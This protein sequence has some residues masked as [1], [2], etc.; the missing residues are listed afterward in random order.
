MCVI[1]V[2]GAETGGQTGEQQAMRASQEVDGI[3]DD[4]SLGWVLASVCVSVCTQNT[5]G[6]WGEVGAW[7]S[8]SLSVVG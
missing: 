7:R 5:Q 2:P 4:D 8:H 3:F 1:S 6:M